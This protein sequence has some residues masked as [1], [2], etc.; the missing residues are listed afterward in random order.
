MK[1]LIVLFIL[2]LASIASASRYRYYYNDDRSFYVRF[3]AS[4]SLA[5]NFTFTWPPDDG[6]S[7][8]QLTTDG[9][10]VL[11]WGDA[12]GAAAGVHSMLNA[13]THSDTVADTVTRG[14][15]IIG[16]ATPKWDELDLGANSTILRSDGTDAVWAATTNI[17]QLG[18]VSAG[19][20]QGTPVADAYVDDDISL[21]SVGQAD[22]VDLTDVATNDVLKYNGTNFVVVPYNQDLSFS[23]ASFTDNESTTQLIGSGVWETTGN[24]TFDAT[25]N[26]GPPSAA[27]VT[28]SSDDGGYSAWETNPLV[29]TSP[30]A[31][32]DTTENTNYP[33]N[34]GE[35]VR[36]TLDTTPT[37]SDTETVT[38]QNYL[39]YGDGV[40]ADTYLEADVEAE[41]SILS[42][43]HTRSVTIDAGA[44]EYLVFSYPTTY[45]QIPIGTDYEDD[46]GGTGFVFNSITCACGLDNAALSITNSAGYAED[47]DVVVSTTAN[48][49]NHT[50]T[51]Y[52]SRTAINTIYWGY[53]TDTSATEATIEGLSGGSSTASNDNTRT[54]TVT[55]G[56]SEYI[57]FAYPKRLGEVTFWV[58]GF[59]GGFEAV[60]TDSV[61]NSNGWSEDYYSYRSTNANLGET[62]VTTQ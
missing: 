39:W 19:T 43:D 31:T 34:R 7:G 62:E 57:Y 47:Y 30:F 21:A 48:L 15:L 37:D 16:N 33:S 2:L 22:N 11:S 6:T 17:T 41:T 56:A 32:K 9:S 23:I 50:L 55:P 4:E 27:T 8:Y 20:W 5:D 52:T 36:F 42:S 1:K 49:G 25:Y 46:G 12:E 24:I 51:T 29:M 54:F 44:G 26:N 59:E 53:H 58:G 40:K 13:G 60:D 38:F 28:V 45:T 10:G 61:G 18:T 3:I 14:S 35:Y